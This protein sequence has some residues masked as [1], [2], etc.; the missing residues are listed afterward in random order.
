[1]DKRRDLRIILH[2][3]AIFSQSGYA[4][5]LTWL[6]KRLLKEGFAV[7]QATKAGLSTHWIDYKLDEGVLRMY[8]S[9]DDPHG[10][11]TLFYGA[12][13]FNAHLAISMID[14]WVMQ[15]QF[16]QQLKQLGVK[17]WA[18]MPIDSDPVAPGVLKNLP[19]LDKIITFSTFGQKTLAKHGFASEMIYEG[20]DTDEL[21]PRDKIEARKKY[22]I[23]TDNFYWGMI[24]AN[25]ENPPRKGWQ[26]ALEAFKLF[27]EKHPEAA[28]FLQTQQI[29]LGNFPIMEYATH[30]K[31][32]HRI[33]A[34]DQL[35]SSIM[36][37][38][39]DIVWMLN[40]FD[41]LLHP[42]QTE[43]FGLTPIEAASCGVPAVVNGSHSQPELVIEGV[44]G[45]VAKPKEGHKR[46]TNSGSYWLPADPNAI[47]EG[48]EKVY[49]MLKENPKKVAF[50]CRKHVK[51]TF[52]IDK[53]FSERWLPLLE[54]L[55][56]KLPPQLTP[57]VET[58]K[59]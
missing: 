2:G 26:E 6:I 36:G 23:P 25:K 54:N 59:I 30:L 43:G 11:D 48:M 22:G 4:V 29:A 53:I 27:Y 50:D 21:V 55:Q 35:F 45:V 7:A 42:S 58:P 41:G 3:D 1:M 52:N 14:I 13:H 32:N 24:A 34:L 57:L 38:R 15:P 39:D 31:I 20:V 17:Y 47:Y 10:S 18:Y 40:C 37:T 28:I 12:R 56:D 5:E 8:P 44:T 33:F 49:S 46:W 51:E 9:I 19:F 16:L